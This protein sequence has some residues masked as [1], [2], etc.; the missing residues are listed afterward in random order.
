MGAC[1][2]TWKETTTRCPECLE[3]H[4]LY[5]NRDS[6]LLSCPKRYT[7]RCFECTY[8]DYMLAEDVKLYDGK[9]EWK[10]CFHVLLFLSIMAS[11]IPLFLWVWVWQFVKFCNWLIEIGW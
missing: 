10:G 7:V 1:K 4:H 6:A 9:P 8:R 3:Y 5:V 11:I 2:T